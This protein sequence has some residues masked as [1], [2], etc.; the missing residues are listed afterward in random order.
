[1]DANEFEG[2]LR[3]CANDKSIIGIV[4]AMQPTVPTS[5]LGME[6]MFEAVSRYAQFSP[7]AVLLDPGY[8]PGTNRRPRNEVQARLDR[9]RVTV[10]PLDGRRFAHLNACRIK[11]ISKLL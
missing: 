8:T 9:F 5:R 1:M 4:V 2:A 3:K 7:V 10:V 11:E 6:E